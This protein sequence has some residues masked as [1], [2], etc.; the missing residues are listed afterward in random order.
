MKN[1]SKEE[2]KVLNR[3]AKDWMG[4]TYRQLLEEDPEEAD[5]VYCYA[6]ENGLL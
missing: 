5:N 4:C 1:Y 3:I 2:L 6:E